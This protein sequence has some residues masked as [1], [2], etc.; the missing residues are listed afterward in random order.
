M[1][2]FP[3]I[4]PVGTMIGSVVVEAANGMLDDKVGT[5]GT[6]AETWTNESVGAPDSEFRE[7]DPGI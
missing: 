1:R 4:P 6:L 5:E 3:P 7:L 2:G